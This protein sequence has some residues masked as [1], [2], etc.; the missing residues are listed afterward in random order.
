MR[1]A[2]VRRQPPAEEGADAA[3]GA[4][5]ELIGDDD[6]ERDAILP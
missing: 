2:H 6:V 5:D 3:A 4:I 1:E